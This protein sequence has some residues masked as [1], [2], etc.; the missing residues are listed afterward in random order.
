MASFYN[1]TVTFIGHHFSLTT[2]IDSESND[3][4]VV[5]D[6]AVDLLKHYYDWDVLDKS[7]QIDVTV[8]VYDDFVSEN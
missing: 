8:E 7:Y 2:H 3:P 4:E 6:E 5:S 1:C